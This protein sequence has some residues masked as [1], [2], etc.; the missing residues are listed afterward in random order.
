MTTWAFTDDISDALAPFLRSRTV[1]PRLLGLGEPTHG[2]EEFLRLRNAAFRYLVEHAG[3]RS[4]AIESDCLAA[5]TVDAFVTDGTG[6]LDDAM[7]AG[8]SHGFDASAGNRELIG[9]MRA[10][11]R[12]RASRDRVRFFGFDPPIEITGAACP[13][14]A[15]AALHT[16]LAAILG[17]DRLPPAA[18]VD[19]LIG[20]PARWTDPAAMMDPARSVGHHPDVAELRLLTDDLVTV[21]H[22]QS[23]RLVAATSLDDWWQADL[24]G[25]TSAGLLRYHVA[26]A[27]PSRERIGWLMG[28]RDEMGAANLRA[29]LAREARRGPTLAFAGNGHLQ[30]DLSVWRPEWP[31]L[32]GLVLEWWSAGAIVAAQLGEEYAFLATAAG[33]IPGRGLQ[34]S[35]PDT[36]EGTLSA[37]PQHRFILDGDHLAELAADTVAR[38]D[39]SAAQGYSALDPAAVSGTDGVVFVREVRPS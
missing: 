12:D 18:D 31:G 17:T 37:L 36:L 19:R 33:S 29:I 38:T 23:P 34:P 39:I 15:L 5:L 28:L 8:F 32:T 26:T 4:V 3:Y 22:A 14:P 24:H 10:Y 21:L 30:R 20:D 1:P 6:S 11:N 25:R 35:A 16:Y 27:E 7:T 13:G 9:W 2:E